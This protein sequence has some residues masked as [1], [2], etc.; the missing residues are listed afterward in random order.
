MKKSNN[1]SNYNFIL[2]G[3]LF[4]INFSATIVLLFTSTSVAIGVTIKKFEMTL[5]DVSDM[6]NQSI[7][8][9]ATYLILNVILIYVYHWVN[10]PKKRLSNPFKRK[11]TI[12]ELMKQQQEH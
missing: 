10:T 7:I 8:F 1:I 3:C 5:A 11:R 6:L 2:L 12:G 9:I 4:I